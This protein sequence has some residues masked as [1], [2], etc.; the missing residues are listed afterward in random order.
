LGSSTQESEI[1]QAIS[2]GKTKYEIWT[3]GITD[4]P[5]RRKSEHEAQDENVK[6]WKD[7]KADTETIARNVEKY[8]LD[9]GMK[10][11]TG[12]GEH[13]TYVYIF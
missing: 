5:E 12:G 4:D 11:S 6:Y 7:W 2:L 3:I 1:I 10:G 8:F 13:P 9:K